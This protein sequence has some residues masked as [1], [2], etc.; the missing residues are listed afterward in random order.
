MDVFAWLRGLGL[1]QYEA[2]FRDNA[3]DDQILPSLTADELKE[4]GVAALGHRRRLLDAISALR[5]DGARPSA[6]G[7]DPQPAPSPSLAR[8]TAERRPITVMFC[9]L[10]GSTSMASA[11]DAEDWRELVGGYLDEAAGAVNQYGGHVLKKLGDGLMAL[12]GY[13]T[14]LE[15]DAER[16]ARA[17]LA[18]LGA[19]ED[20]NVRN[21]ARG[22][23]QLSARIGLE[24]GPVVVDRTGE[25]FGDVPNV[26][27]RVQSAAE[28]GTLLV[29]AAVQRQVAGLFIAED[30]GPHELKGVPGKPALYRLVRASGG[31]RRASGRALTPLVGREEELTAL[32]RRWERARAGEGQFV[33]VVGEPGLGK[34][35]LLEEFRLR[36][37]ERP[38]TWVEWASSQLLQNTPLHP[39][40]DWGRHRFA[41]EDRFAELEAAL[42]QVKLDPAEHASLLAPLLDIPL[43][44]DRAPRIAADELRRRQLA[45]LVTWLLAGARAQALVLSIEDLHWSDP[46]TLDVIKTLAECGAQAQL[47]IIATTRPEFRAPWTMRSHHS[48]I[49]LAALDR[50]QIGQMVGAIAERHALSR[51][52]VEGLSDR[53]GGVP[54]FV[55]E[56]TRLVLEGG[57]KIIPPSLQ[58]SLA[59]RLDRLGEARELAQIG[60]VLGRQF[61][62]TLLR[63]VAETPDTT[64]DAALEKLVDADLLFAEGDASR[65]VYCFKHALIQ[66]AAYDSLLKAQRQTLHQRAAEALLAS[67]DPQPELVAHHFTQSRQTE[68]A[69]EWWS[70]A[71]DS[72]LNR[73]AFQEA[74]SHLAK[75]IEMVDNQV[76]STKR[77]DS[78]E[79]GP[80]PE[81]SAVAEAKALVAPSEQPWIKA[82][83]FRQDRR[84]RLQ[85]SYAKALMWAQGPNTPGAEAAMK[86]AL[87]STSRALNPTD[88]L[89]IFY[90]ESLRLFVSGRYSDA[91]EAGTVF[92]ARAEADMD[93]PAILLACRRLG[94]VTLRQ[95]KL[96]EAESWLGRALQ[97]VG[98]A[99][100]PVKKIVGFADD[101]AMTNAFLGTVKWLRGDFSTARAL[102]EVAI[103]QAARK[104][105]APSLANARNALTNIECLRNSETSALRAAEDLVAGAEQSGMGNF[106][107]LGKVQVAWARGCMSDTTAHIGCIRNALSARAEFGAVDL[108]PLFHGLLADLLARDGDADGALSSVDV[109]LRIAEET[110]GHFTDSYLL[111]LR[112]DILCKAGNEYRGLAMEA[113]RAAMTISELQGARSLTVLAAL[114]LGRLLLSENRPLEADDVLASTLEGFSA[115]PE[116]PAIAEA[117]ALLASLAKPQ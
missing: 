76:G 92:L 109:G 7:V 90:S 87:K 96:D 88:R 34:S 114:P 2:P 51:E 91:Y 22:L 63:A 80:T 97:L 20:L 100:E 30:R 69:I 10:V 15:N 27:A 1:G 116:L 93:S 64:L 72:A 41:S 59:A 73:S 65:E 9:D 111:R 47:L 38:H 50:G 84:A 24:S 74:F 14:A 113:Y 29:T 53:T 32:A 55:E 77:K 37:G 98:K 101:E 104:C 99:G 25:V 85:T 23:P 61:S 4:I 3:I 66:D 16:A 39:L 110:G 11:M 13:P 89:S 103:E 19:L 17:G 58:Q 56:L 49:A 108:A 79:W 31:R 86:Q 8:D 70:I 45:A 67:T 40:A 60:A 107:G 33:Q 18:I 62:L 35:R 83:T 106:L 46:T 43:P 12:F 5:N 54:L 48:V 57:A 105:D 52:V 112:G 36:L 75:A 26:A 117:Q 115:T 28:P 71:G 94:M 82:D 21:T 6:D 42:T 68:A 81:L 78:S 44:M 95:G 102:I